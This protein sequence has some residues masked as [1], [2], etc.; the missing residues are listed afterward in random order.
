MFKKQ[1]AGKNVSYAIKVGIDIDAMSGATI[2]SRAVS[3]GVRKI[4]HIWR[5]CFGFVEY[6]GNHI[7]TKH[8]CSRFLKTY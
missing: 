1:F 8:H 7:L 4:I 5:E 2:S 3:S 6:T